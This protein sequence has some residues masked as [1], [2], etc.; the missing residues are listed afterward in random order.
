MGSV[1]AGGSLGGEAEELADLGPGEAL[2]AGVCHGV[3]EH[4]SGLGEEA[5]EGVQVDA[6]VAEP[7]RGAQPGQ[8]LGDRRKR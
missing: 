1:A 5:G 8:G 7:V 4:R 2:V 6:G 3:G